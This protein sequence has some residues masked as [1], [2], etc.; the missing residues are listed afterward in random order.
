MLQD[1]MD[2][3]RDGISSEIREEAMKSIKLPSNENIW[4]YFV[5]KCTANLHVILCMN[6]SGDVLRN[7]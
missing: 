2:Q 7:R 6:P 4:D 3:E 1:F 5:Q